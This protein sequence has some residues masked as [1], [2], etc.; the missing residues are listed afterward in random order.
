MIVNMCGGSCG[1]SKPLQLLMCKSLS[2]RANAFVDC[3]FLPAFPLK[4]PVL[5]TYQTQ[6]AKFTVWISMLCAKFESDRCAKH[7]VSL[8]C[9][10]YG[11]CRC[12]HPL[13]KSDECANH[14]GVQTNRFYFILY[15]TT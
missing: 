12:K 10:M 1:L 8:Y 5:H 6:C 11:V 7:T 2:E 15:F 14:R 13:C 4:L 3:S 9:K